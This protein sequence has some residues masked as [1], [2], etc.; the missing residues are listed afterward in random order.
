MFDKIKL[1]LKKRSAYRLFQK[2]LRTMLD[3]GVFEY[4][5]DKNLC[6]TDDF[7]KFCISH[8][9]TRMELSSEN[10]DGVIT[11]LLTSHAVTY[12]EMNGHKVNVNE[13]TNITTIIGTIVK[14][15]EL[16]E[17]VERVPSIDPMFC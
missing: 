13:V 7:I 10:I 17:L 2:T 12:I 4:T 15:S 1:Y 8:H 16:E 14:M 5:S 3:A 11:L 9:P 6:F